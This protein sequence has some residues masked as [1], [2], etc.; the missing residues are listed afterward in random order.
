MSFSGDFL[1]EYGLFLFLYYLKE[2]LCRPIHHLHLGLDYL[3]K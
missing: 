3:E 2:R 1:E